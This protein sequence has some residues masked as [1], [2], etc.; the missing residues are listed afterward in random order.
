MIYDDYIAYTEEYEKKYG[1]RTIV[2]MEVGSFFE[3]YAIRNE[4][5]TVGPDIHYIADICNLQVSRKNKTILENNRK[6]PLMAG[7]PSVSKGKHVEILLSHQYT[8]VL[9]EQV[10]PPPNIERKVTEILSPSMQLT[11]SST[12]GNYLMV[13]MWDIYTDKL[14]CR[15]LSLGIAGM[16]VSTGKTWIYEGVSRANA[17]DE[18]TRCFQMYQ[19][20]EVIFIGNNLVSK[21]QDDI[22]A[23]VNDL[24][25]SY[26]FLWNIDIKSY[27]NINYQNAV[28]EKAFEV[29]MLNPIEF[30]EMERYDNAR[31]AFVYMIQFGYEHNENVIKFLSPPKHI[32]FTGYCILEYNSALQLQC[33]SA[34]D[35][36]GNERPLINILNRCATA[37]GARQYRERFLQP[38]N[39][40]NLLN[41]RYQAIDDMIQSGNYNSIHSILKNVLDLERIA[42]RIVLGRFNPC[43]WPSFHNSL[44]AIVKLDIPEIKNLGQIIINSYVN[45]LNLEVAGKYLMNDIKENIF[46]VGICPQSDI[47][48][49][50]KNEAYGL[51]TSLSETFEEGAKVEYNDKDG[52]FISM[53]K[54]RWETAKTRMSNSTT[55]SIYHLNVS[56]FKAKPISANSSIIHLFHPWIEVQSNIIMRSTTAI[57]ADMIKFYKTFM[58]N[59]A[60]QIKDYLIE[61]IKLVGELDI[62][63]TNAR[64]A[65]KYNYRRPVI[66]E[67]ASLSTAS[68]IK[69]N[70]LRHP[71]IEII[72]NKYKYVPND[73]ALGKD[74]E[75]TGLLL[76]GMNASGKSSL[77]K[78][79]GLNLIMAQAG[80]YVAAS[81]FEYVPYDH[82]FTRI[83]GAD[84]IYRG[85][86]S[87][88]VEMLELKNILQRAN[89]NSL[90]LGDELCA[91]TE[92]ISALAIVAAG[93]DMLL[94]KVATF[95]F[96]T[97]LHDLGKMESIQNAEKLRLRLAHM[98]VDVSAD[99][100]IIFD[101]KLREGSGSAL[102]GLEVCKGL[103]LPSEFIK[104]AHEIRCEITEI[105][106]EFVATKTSRYNSLVYVGECKICGVKASETHHI[107]HQADADAN[108]FIDGQYHMNRKFN[109][110]SVCEECHKRIH[111]GTLHLQGYQETSAGP[112]LI[113]VDKTRIQYN[114][115]TNEW[116]LRKTKRSQWKVATE[117]EVLGFCRKIKITENLTELQ[118]MLS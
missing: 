20:R 23:T 80:M 37:F 107:E 87:F 11:P 58:D 89:A 61:L 84:N 62:I 69:A 31:T 110:I 41:A 78:S 5:E 109:L 13:C 115:Q 100:L 32:S 34:G 96:A 74:Q 9:I 76:F 30:L 70:Q 12:D 117:E 99:G 28:L 21:E 106:P 77:M 118:R 65:L 66:S 33:I 92:S 88:T 90:V 104:R 7:F 47:I 49:I 42:R 52:Y 67:S 27:E 103:G 64:N 101:R 98:H 51:L 45:I 10:T 14:N 82:I 1:E 38:I 8:V 24:S 25:R 17:I 71:I 18:F 46:A 94:N 50:L 44:E 108:G 116:L 75:K 86:S 114:N 22:R 6:N 15:H 81:S 60:I 43:D 54:R 55:Y 56:E 93:I 73:I 83:S 36:R 16:D 91:G 4:E 26:H 57:N 97:H 19:P 63:C 53:T 3:M 111:N 48:N 85:W 68:Y 39:D 2:L 79:I 113:M 59:I 72:N 102:Y 40:S 29:G 112:K 95:V 105:S 35:T